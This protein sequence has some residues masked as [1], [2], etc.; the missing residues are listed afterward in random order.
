MG[1]TLLAGTDMQFGGIM[2]HRELRNLAI[3]GLS[4][5]D[6]IAT[7]TSVNASA[8]GLDGVSGTIRAGLRA[9]MV[10]LNGDPL[11]NLSALRDIDTVLKAGEFVVDRGIIN[12]PTKR[13]LS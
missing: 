6:V 9:D 11:A 7:A 8:V 1:G 2:L 12:P 4:P 3:L 13:A 10:V 5:L